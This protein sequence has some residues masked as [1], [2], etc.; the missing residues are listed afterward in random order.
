MHGTSWLT[1]GK[2]MLKLIAFAGYS[3]YV[4]TFTSKNTNAV[5]SLISLL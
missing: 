5:L 4:H 2:A 1:K 3:I